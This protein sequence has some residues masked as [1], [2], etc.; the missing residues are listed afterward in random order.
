MMFEEGEQEQHQEAA[1][2]DVDHGDDIGENYD[3]G[4]DDHNQEMNKNFLE[5]NIKK[6]LSSDWGIECNSPF[7]HVFRSKKSL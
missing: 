1:D 5:H 2:D 3:A 7:R 4:D 6:L